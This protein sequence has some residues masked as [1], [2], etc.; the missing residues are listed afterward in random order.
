MNEC[1]EFSFQFDVQIQRAV[2]KSRSAAATAV[3]LDS[4]HGGFLH[5]GMG[6]QVQV[7]VGPKHEYFTVPHTHF[8]SPTALAVAKNLEVHVEPGGLQVTRTSEISAFLENVVRGAA[9]S[10]AGGVASR[11]AHG[12]QF[13]S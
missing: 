3:L 8:A 9:L 2:E 5:L 7:V 11:Y 10:F 1:G 6:D 12:P 13:Q 4:L